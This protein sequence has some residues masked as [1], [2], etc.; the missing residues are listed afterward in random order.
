MWQYFYAHAAY[1]MVR[2]F[3]QNNQ[4]K[5]HL[6]LVIISM[7]L[8]GSQLY[9]ISCEKSSRY[10]EQPLLNM[11]IASIIL[12]FFTFGFT[13][14][15]GLLIP[16]PRAVKICFHIY[17]VGCL[18][19]GLLYAYYTFMA[20]TTCPTIIPELFMLSEFCSYFSLLA[21][22]FFVVLFPFWV[23]NKVKTNLVLDP[24]SRTGV[25][26]EPTKCC[27]CLWHI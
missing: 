21:T 2:W 13:I 25:C 16:V 27:T 5:M 17:G 15:F 18:V 3:P 19:H 11:A 12:T 23:I 4:R 24:Y 14:L 9:V 6:F 7:A 10:C 8:P 20:R 1:H 22:A 26:Y